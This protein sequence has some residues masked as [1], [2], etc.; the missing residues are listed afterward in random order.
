[1]PPNWEL[2]SGT[3]STLVESLLGP[4]KRVLWGKVGS[5]L[6]GGVLLAIWT[7]F[8]RMS[9]VIGSVMSLLFRDI[10]AFIER[11]YSQFGAAMVREAAATWSGAAIDL[12]F[13]QLPYNLV[14][15]LLAFSIMA[16]GVSKLNG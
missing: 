6:F 11:Q 5:A 13:L 15:V 10:P 9:Q 2:P 3:G 7:G 1:M 14:T 8:I 12:G 4:D 16:W